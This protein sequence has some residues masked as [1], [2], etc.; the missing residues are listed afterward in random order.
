MNKEHI[1]NILKIDG[2]RVIITNNIANI[3]RL[4]RIYEKE[5]SVNVQQLYIKSL[6][7]IAKEFLTA[8]KAW[9]YCDMKGINIIDNNVAACL[10]NKIIT[11]SGYGFIPEES[12]CQDTASELV[13]IVNQIRENGVT[14]EYNTAQSAKIKDI[15]NV[16]KEYEAALGTKDYDDN[17]SVIK[18]VLSILKC[19]TSD[20]Q[21]QK[22]I[23]LYVPWLK[24][25]DYYIVKDENYTSIENELI[26]LLSGIY[27]KD[28]TELDYA[29]ECR[30]VRFNFFKTYG[31]VNEVEYIA[32]KIADEKIATGDVNIF[33]TDSIY[34]RLIRGIFEQKG[35]KFILNDGYGAKSLGFISVIVNLIEFALD[36]Y[37]YKSLEKVMSDNVISLSKDNTINVYNIYL[38]EIRAGIGWGHKR[39]KEYIERN[40]ESSDNK[41]LPDEYI[42][43]IDDIYN[44]FNQDKAIDIYDHIIEWLRKYTINNQTK[45]K[46]VIPL[47]K[48]GRT[49]IAEAD[50]KDKRQILLFLK[51]YI[52]SL[53]VQDVIDKEENEESVQIYSMNHMLVLERKHNFFIGL[54][55]KQFLG[56]VS[57]SP[58][59]SD[60]QLE[61]YI[62]DPQIT[63]K[64]IVERQKKTINDTIASLCSGNIYMGYSMYDTIEF[65]DMSMASIYMDYFMNKNALLTNKDVK[66]ACNIADGDVIN[67]SDC[68]IMNNSC[69]YI[70]GNIGNIY[71]DNKKY[72]YKKINHAVRVDSDRIDKEIQE[73]INNSDDEGKQDEEVHIVSK[74]KDNHIMMSSTSLQTLLQCP[75]KY[76]YQYDCHIPF[77]EFLKPEPMSWLTPAGKGN[78]F[79]YTMEKYC[80]LVVDKEKGILPDTIDEEAFKKAYEESVNDVYRVLPYV[81]EA[82]FNEEKILYGTIIRKYIEKFHI[83]FMQNKGEGWHII[84]EECDF[85][86]LEYND[87]KLNIYFSGSIDRLDARVEAGK[88]YLRIID[89]KTGSYDAKKQE[90]LNNV[91]IQHYIYASA[92]VQYVK[93]NIEKLRRMMG[94]DFTEENIVVS[95]VYYVFPY[96]T[97]EACQQISSLAVISSMLLKNKAGKSTT[98]PEYV[99][100][101]KDNKI[102]PEN[103]REIIRNTEG[104]RISGAIDKY[105]DFVKKYIESRDAKKREGICKYC[106]YDGMCMMKIK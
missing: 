30:N 56:N 60:E 21:K 35:I 11:D 22:D 41:H 17:I 88:I 31:V 64:K 57:E 89:Y 86:R 100:L 18:K 47:L 53:R 99:I 95:D 78:L 38:K 74:E 65:K 102:L 63:T 44:I 5:Q 104:N 72:E 20:E 71:I 33:Y 32:D 37:S 50:I 2:K 73:Y 87:D 81:S 79:H 67:N 58:V 1:K 80:K 26:L 68:S 45:N 54:T 46:V 7:D 43:F 105:T 85:D 106:T 52:C 16:V 101:Q 61:K 40:R 55:A 29:A 6:F 39:Y 42:D 4:L 82:V 70:D 9:N 92:A 23:E 36:D 14:D 25:C 98:E 90:I 49:Y 75:L 19:K 94:D 77:K 84:G 24:K 8:Y 48:A 91:Q 83:Q 3:N 97:D 96:E 10:M 12:I 27:N 15:R 62:I 34:E 93:E 69:N 59:L 76:Y 66:N 13:K 28:I 51:D 103:I